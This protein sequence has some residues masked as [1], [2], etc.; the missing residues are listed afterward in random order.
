MNI[1]EILHLHSLWL[2]SAP[3]GVRA[4]LTGADL[5]RAYLSWANLIEANLTR[6]NLSG[7]NLTRANLTRANLIEANLTR[8]NLSGADLTGANLTGA[9]LSGANLTR[10]NLT[11]A[12]LDFSS[13]P[14]WC[15]S[16]TVIVDVDQA[17]QLA[18]HLAAILPTE[19]VGEWVAE[20]QQFANEWTGIK[21][22]NIEPLERM[23]R[24]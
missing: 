10:A 24:Y 9:N 8:A 20:L 2:T 19:V 6:A 18:Y 17:R 1:K 11:R 14:L 15:G 16:L 3:D 21:R 4:D 12:T 23:V 5:T 22:H 7:A 13:W